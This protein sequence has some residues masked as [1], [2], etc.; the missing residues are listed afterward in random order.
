M[1]SRP[2]QLNQL[3][4]LAQDEANRFRLN[5][6]QSARLAEQAKQHLYGG[7]PMHWMADW[8][9]PFPLFVQAA[10]GACF[11][12]VDDHRYADFCL[13]DTGSMF[14]HSPAPV[15]Q[16]IAEQAAHGYT[17][18]LPSEDAIAVSQQLSE[19]FGLAFWQIAT[20]ATDAN[21]WALRWA[22]AVTK[23]KVIVVFDG[24]Y[25]GTVDETMVR[26]HNGKT[27]HRKGLKGQALDLTQYMR[28]VEFNDL[29]AL[30]AALQ[31]HDVAAVLCEPVMTNIGMVLPEAGF[32][33]ELRRLTRAYGTLLILDETHTISTGYGGYTQAFGLEPDLFV[34]GKPIAGGL[35]CSVLGMSAEV[36]QS[37]QQ[38]NTSNN[39]NDHDGHG[40]SGMGTTLSANMFTMRA[41]RANLEQ[42]M[43]RAAY[44][45][46]IP[47][48]EYLA[49]GLR[50]MLAQHQLAWCI[51]QIGARVEF[52]FSAT[53]P[54]TGHAAELAFDDELEQ[55]IHLYLLN[56]GIMITPFHNMMLVCPATQVTDID[57][58][59]QTLAAFIQALY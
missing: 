2:Y 47:K 31:N 40:H 33:A 20:T 7:V 52:Q 21:R 53:P 3:I 55:C 14:G 37:M 6:P 59:I 39:P 57:Q 48:A 22:R 54:R 58:L 23:R 32:H 27:V 56:R 35:P 26:L 9:T 50:A 41:M 30:Q 38:L 5:H 29:D 36:A 46:M 28:V 42:V 4:A 44:Q 16:V 19:R 1:T 49:Q 12:D 8:S 13:G 18:M 34:L 17:T 45:D 25:H 15:A 11:S 24:C 43:T 51:T 10:K